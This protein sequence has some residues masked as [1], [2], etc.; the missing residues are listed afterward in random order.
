M[1]GWHQLNGYEFEQTLGDS[2]GQGSLVC[3]SPWGCKKSDT[4][5]WLK[6]AKGN[7][8]IL[9]ESDK[10]SLGV[11]VTHSFLFTALYHIMYIFF[12]QTLLSDPMIGTGWAV[13][14]QYLH[15][16]GSR[17]PPHP[18]RHQKPWMLKS[19]SQPSIS[20]DAATC[21]DRGPTV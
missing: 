14:S 19:Y 9:Q 17:T 13:I 12:E 3:Y 4:T 15:G 20:T 21:G 10:A 5:Q 7:E 6:T 1:V 8:Y 16:I 2:E 18:R 11:V